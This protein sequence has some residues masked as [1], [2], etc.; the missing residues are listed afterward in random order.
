MQITYSP[1]FLIA[2]VL[3]LLPRTSLAEDHSDYLE[4][5]FNS[6]HEVTEACLDCHDDAADSFMKSIHW[7]WGSPQDLPGNQVSAI[8]GK[9]TVLNN[10]CI[11]LES[12]EARCTSCHAGY[13]WKDEKFDFEDPL[14]IDCLVCHESTGTYKKF[15][16]K[17][18][19]PVDRE[20]EFPKGSGKLFKIPDLEKIAMSVGE[21]PT[22]TA[23]GSC[24]F[25]GG[26]GNNVKHGDLDA[27]L[28]NPSRELD[29]H[30]GGA[31]M[32][33]VDCHKT[34]DHTITG[35]AMSVS[36]HGSETL[37]CESCHGEE[38]H[39][40]YSFYLNAHVGALA[41]QTCHIPTFARENP[42]KL[43]WDWSQ[44][45]DPDRKVNKDENG[46]PDYNKKKGAFVWGRNVVP[47]YEWYNGASKRMLLGD[48]VELNKMNTM[49]A[50][51]GSKTDKLSKIYPF[52]IHTGKQIA[53]KK[54]KYLLPTHLFGGG[55]WDHFDW[56]KSVTVG[57]E[58]N[59]LEYSGSY[60]F[61]ETEM[62]WEIDH[63]VA[64][65]EDALVCKSCHSRSKDT[66]IDWKSLGYEGDP[67]YTKDQSRTSMR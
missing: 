38:P 48:P 54:N 28:I 65:K 56:E 66:R 39:K 27:A 13:G 61:V 55:Y 21:P 25:Y 26:G 16:S 23:C 50:P 19:Y 57:V 17:A 3:A 4:G 7:T 15:P 1:A 63:M 31:D 14:N 67:R 18:G 29:V 60:T 49:A 22:R 20:T 36:T 8:I 35:K 52:K 32:T 41:C 37:T 58:K 40:K 34:N 6:V 51:I 12:N 42:T 33:C 53:D 10:F 44:A 47:T 59:G 64:P 62:Y 30:M 43:R 46:M 2:I 5:P 45:G 24:H 9:R 11:G